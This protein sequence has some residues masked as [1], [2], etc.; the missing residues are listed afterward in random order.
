MFVSEFTAMEL[1]A[2]LRVEREA[3]RASFRVIDWVVPPYQRDATA[4]QRSQCRWLG[5]GLL[6]VIDQLR[7]RG[8]DRRRPT[9]P[10]RSP[11]FTRQSTRQASTIWRA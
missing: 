2:E 11:L 9:R 8:E 1:D 10:L 7:D 6:P 3:N 4:G 5:G